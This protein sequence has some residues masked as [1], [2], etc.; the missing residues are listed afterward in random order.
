MQT[1]LPYADYEQAARCLDDARI[2]NQC[3]RECLTLY[4]GGWQNHPASK[5]WQGYSSSLARYALALALE[6]QY[7]RRPCAGKWIRYW[8]DRVL[9]S[10]QDPPWLG[11][12]DFHRSH[13]SNLLRKNPVWY[14]QFNWDVPDDLPYI[15]PTPKDY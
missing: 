2:G 11:D 4:N 12:L 6:L 9:P 15:W 1:F 7:R 3:Y 8:S 13:Q 14:R 5:M 10:S